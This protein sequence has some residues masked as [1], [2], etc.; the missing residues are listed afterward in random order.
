MRAAVLL[1]AVVACGD[2]TAASGAFE[3][4]GHADLGAA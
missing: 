2:N 4:V 3:I 1:C